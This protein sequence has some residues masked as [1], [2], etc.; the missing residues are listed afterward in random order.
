MSVGVQRFDQAIDSV[1]SK[2]L[3][4]VH[5]QMP[6]VVTAVNIGSSDPKVDVSILWEGVSQENPSLNYKYAEIYDVPVTMLAVSPSIKITVPVKVGTFG[7]VQFPE[8]PL[9]SFNGKDKVSVAITSE[10]ISHPLMG[11][12]FIPSYHCGPIDPDNIIIKNETSTITIKK[13]SIDIAAPTGMSINGLTIT[14]DGDVVTKDGVSLN[15]VKAVY[16]SHNHG[17]G[18]TPTP[19]L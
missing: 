1:I 17:G 3:Y 7:V 13:D 8:K 9:Y 10:K 6:C 12:S 16:N 18:P 14:P 2:R 19:Q 15:N 11:L 5:T 4:D